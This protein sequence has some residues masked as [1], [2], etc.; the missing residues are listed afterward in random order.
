MPY[1]VSSDQFEP[2]LAHVIIVIHMTAPFRALVHSIYYTPEALHFM[3]PFAS[4]AL[5]EGELQSLLLCC[6]LLFSLMCAYVN[7][8]EICSNVPHIKGENVKSAYFC[9][10]AFG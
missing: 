2:L 10:I 3:H 1:F 6:A 4:I 7:M 9:E 5:C 8:G